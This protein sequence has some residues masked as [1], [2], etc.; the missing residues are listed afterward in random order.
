VRNQL[1]SDNM[2]KVFYCCQIHMGINCNINGA[3]C[4]CLLVA[5]E[6][7]KQTG[8]SSRHSSPNNFYLSLSQKQ[9]IM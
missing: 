3:V 4:G 1:L 9:K 5:E 7:H 6:Q 8:Q 2:F